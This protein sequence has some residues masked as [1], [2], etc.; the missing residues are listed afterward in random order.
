LAIETVRVWKREKRQKLFHMVSLVHSFLLRLL[1]KEHKELVEWI[2]REYC[3]RRGKK[4]KEAV[5]PLY[6]LRWA[7]SR[8][9]HEIRP[10]FVFPGNVRSSIAL[11]QGSNTCS[12][13]SG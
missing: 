3:H 11:S 1:D 2:L 6:R 12:Q 13:N 4:H 7:L 5:A 10:E 9:Y 8:F